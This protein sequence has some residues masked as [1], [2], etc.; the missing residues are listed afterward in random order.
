M[1]AKPTR[2]ESKASSPR[3]VPAASAL[4]KGERHRRKKDHDLQAL[5]QY[6][7]RQRD[8][9]PD[10]IVGVVNLDGQL[11]SDCH[12]A[13]TSAPTSPGSESEA[14]GGITVPSNWA[15][16]PPAASLTFGWARGGNGFT[17]TTTTSGPVVPQRTIKPARSRSER[18]GSAVCMI[19]TT[20]GPA[21]RFGVRTK[22]QFPVPAVCGPAR[23]ASRDV[24]S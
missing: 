5:A 23:W 19:D 24:T 2:T 7:S 13:V 22:R 16:L 17:S 4:A 14:P 21:R 20:S 10:W 9:T 18:A 6:H 11:W 3:A 15:M 1:I 8:P 12:G